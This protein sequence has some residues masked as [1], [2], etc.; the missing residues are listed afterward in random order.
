MGPPSTPVPVSSQIHVW[1]QGN[2]IAGPSILEPK[3]PRRP[4][5]GEILRFDRPKK[6][7]SVDNCSLPPGFHASSPI[8]SQC[9]GEKG[10]AIA[11][12]SV[13][14]S[15][16][17]QSQDVLPPFPLSNAVHQLHMSQRVQEDIFTTHVDGNGLGNF[18]PI[19]VDIEGANLI[20][21]KIE[22]ETEWIEPLNWT[23]IVRLLICPSH[24]LH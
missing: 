14:T 1:Q 24:S 22:A 9:D 11:M 17:H 15:V 4:H 10:K 18:A 19:D 2:T 13:S 6:L 12:E 7:H 16:N 3:S 8:R 20:L 21:A 23:V 5:F